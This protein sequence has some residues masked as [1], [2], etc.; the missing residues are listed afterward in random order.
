MRVSLILLAGLAVFM[1]PNFLRSDWTSSAQ[2]E[3]L[4]GEPRLVAAMFRSSWCS[5]CRVLEPRVEDVREDYADRP[6]EFVRFDFTL[7]RRD[8]LRQRAEAE[9]IVEV[10]DELEGRTGFLVLMDR[11]TGQVFEIVTMRY[12]REEIR[13]AFDRWLF[14]TEDRGAS[15]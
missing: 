4:E 7:G 12:G 3:S 8:S 1:V 5:A 14:V 15:T 6:V 9:G 2:A 13:E 10:F 11:E